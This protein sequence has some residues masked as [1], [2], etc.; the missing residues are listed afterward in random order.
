MSHEERA[1]EMRHLVN[2]MIAEDA[3][4]ARDMYGL[5][6]RKLW[7]EQRILWET[8]M[9]LFGYEDEDERTEQ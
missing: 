6:N 9:D 7:E 2:K 3:E 8:E 1:R 4:V 5:S